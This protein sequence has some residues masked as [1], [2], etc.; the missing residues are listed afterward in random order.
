M[1]TNGSLVLKKAGY[2]RY[3][4]SAFAKQEKRADTTKII[5]ILET[6]LASGQGTWET[7]KI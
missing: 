1:E 3:E 6:I 4:V 2:E 7:H 5:G